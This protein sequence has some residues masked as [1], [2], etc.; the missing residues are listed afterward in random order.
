MSQS[1][2]REDH[3]SSS[4]LPGWID[5]DA[6]DTAATA[7]QFLEITDL[8]L[9]NVQ[10]NSTHL[11]RADIL[12]D[13]LGKLQTILEKEQSYDSSS[14]SAS[15]FSTKSENVR[16]WQGQEIDHKRRNLPTDSQ[17]GLLQPPEFQGFDHLRT[18][19]RHLIPRKP[20][21]DKALRQS[22]FIYLKHDE[23]NATSINEVLVVYMP[24]CQN[25]EEMPWYHPKV[26][27][28]AYRYSQSGAQPTLSVLYLPFP[29]TA[30]SDRIERTMLSLLKTSIRLLK[31]PSRNPQEDQLADDM[32]KISLAAASLKDTILPQHIV[33][34][35]YTRLKQAYAMDLIARWVE[36]TE[37]SKHVFEDLA[38]AAFLVELWDTMY[39]K[40]NFPGFIDIA[41]GNGVLTYILIQEGWH[42][43]GFDARR[44]KTWGILGI[45]YLDE[46]VCIP[47]PFL[48]QCDQSEIAHLDIHDG[49]FPDGTFIIS[50]HADE[51][52]CWTPI[53]ATMSNPKIPL[54]FLAI[55]CCS[56]ALDG[57]K[58]R[59]TL[60]EVATSPLHAES[61]DMINDNFGSEQKAV[62]TG[63]LKALRS[64][65]QAAHSHS[66]PGDK[67]MY[68]CLTR[69]TAALAKEL[70]SEV[71][72]T[73]MRIP[74]T[75]NIGVVGNRKARP[76]E[77]NIDRSDL[78]R[79]ILE[80]EC[81]TTGGVR[82]SAITWLGKAKKLQ[83][84]QGRGKVNW[85]GPKP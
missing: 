71:E 1:F 13:S 3:P 83:E 26:K 33:Q 61:A 6:V 41:C 10:L 16:V 35:T 29:D 4:L 53:L 34:N 23:T 14:R 50:N 36:S 82:E 75:R 18:V 43:R 2:V 49:V 12:Y 57:S 85:N 65:K 51:L 20:Q 72:L 68:G 9:E 21:L 62:E 25:A 63:D 31:M 77:A 46:T 15:S 70:G 5:T 81:A 17:D 58:H 66:D 32:S 55:P 59:Y 44:R 56:H 54:P 42:G 67:S 11:F 78:V 28:V 37:P 19:L 74:S 27:G 69:K 84:G 7:K 48:D 73:L 80:R 79:A 47:K 52:T 76:V 39:D 40:S 64:Q 60:K 22:C 38:I 45:D 24:H 8:L 30:V